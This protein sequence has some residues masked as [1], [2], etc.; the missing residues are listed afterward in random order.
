MRSNSGIN[1]SAVDVSRQCAVGGAVPTGL[2]FCC[3]IH[4]RK[5][6]YIWAAGFLKSEERM[7]RNYDESFSLT[8]CRKLAC[9][10]KHGGIIALEIA[11]W[12][13]KNWLSIGKYWLL[14]TEYERNKF[15]NINKTWTTRNFMKT[16]WMPIQRKMG[17]YWQAQNDFF[18]C[19]IKLLYERKLA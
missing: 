2:L 16:M 8:T 14:W 19:R 7:L 11:G 15:W 18:R 1:G 6:P 3:F 12:K 4:N 10:L 9:F 5:P 13:V 17:E